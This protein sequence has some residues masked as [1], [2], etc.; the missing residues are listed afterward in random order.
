MW[1]RKERGFP[2]A[3]PS[4]AI[5]VFG[6]LIPFFSLFMIYSFI[7]TFIFLAEAG[8][9]VRIIFVACLVLSFVLFVIDYRDN[10]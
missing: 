3:N 6:F 1:R 8:I 2:A 10:D 7:S 9:A 5:F 4:L